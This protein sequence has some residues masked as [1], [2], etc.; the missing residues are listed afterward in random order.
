MKNFD[1][2]IGEIVTTD[3]AI[4]GQ[5]FLTFSLFLKGIPRVETKTVFSIF[6]KSEN[7]QICAKFRFAK[8]SIV[9]AKIFRFPGSFRENGYV[10]AINIFKMINSNGNL[11]ILV[12]VH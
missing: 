9:F 12:H 5:H 1:P 4:L 3:V 11:T 7:E 6:A 8:I 2:G 10:S